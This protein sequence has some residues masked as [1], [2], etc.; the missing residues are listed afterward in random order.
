MVEVFQYSL[1]DVKE[2]NGIHKQ[3]EKLVLFISAATFCAESLMTR[4]F[5]NMCVTVS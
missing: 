2:K 3:M 4:L 1:D 5:V